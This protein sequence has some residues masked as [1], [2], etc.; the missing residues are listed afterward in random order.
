MNTEKNSHQYT[1][2][3]LHGISRPYCIKQHEVG[4]KI[5]RYGL[6]QELL[7]YSASLQALNCIWPLLTP[8]YETIKQKDVLENKLYQRRRTI[9]TLSM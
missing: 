2:L 7:M 4:I 8:G 6:V 1:A 9:S 3:M 5:K